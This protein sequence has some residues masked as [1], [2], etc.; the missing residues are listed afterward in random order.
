MIDLKALFAQGRKPE[1]EHTKAEKGDPI[2]LFSSPLAS[3]LL[4][5]PNPPLSPH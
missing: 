2:P 1:P 4:L 3:P 5:N